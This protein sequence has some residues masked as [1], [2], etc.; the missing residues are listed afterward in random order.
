M[1]KKIVPAELRDNMTEKVGALEMKSP[2]DKFKKNMPSIGGKKGKNKV[3]VIAAPVSF[4]D[5]ELEH[6]EYWLAIQSC[7]PWLYEKPKDK[8]S[9]DLLRDFMTLYAK[10]KMSM[11]AVVPGK[12]N[13]SVGK[14]RTN[15]QDLVLTGGWYETAKGEA[16]FAVSFFSSYIS[17]VCGSNALNTIADSMAKQI[18]IY[19][20]RIRELEEDVE[21]R[22]MRIADLENAIKKMEASDRANKNPHVRSQG[23]L[24]GKRPSRVKV[25]PVRMN[26]KR[27]G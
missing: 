1:G 5:A 23:R 19:N 27:R 26:S 16:D 13:V 14:G 6:Y 4:T 22:D 18:K 12:V 2:T 25:K 21:R 8:F 17:S 15:G 10:I 3:S 20:G 7:I 9:K 24:P 11:Q